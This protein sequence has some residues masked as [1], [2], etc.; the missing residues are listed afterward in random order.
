MEVTGCLCANDKDM[1]VIV[2]VDPCLDENGDIAQVIHAVTDVTE[3][4]KSKE[5]LNFE[6]NKLSQYLEVAGVIFTRW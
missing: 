6:K 5:E 1:F 4:V 2:T 3:L